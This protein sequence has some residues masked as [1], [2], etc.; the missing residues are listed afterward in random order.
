MPFFTY[1]WIRDNKWL[2]LLSGIVGLLLISPIAEVYNDQDAIITPITG[3]VLLA[4]TFGTAENR[5]TIWGMG[6]LTLC[7]MIVSIATDGSGLFAGFKDAN[8]VAPV[9]F[10]FI[11][12][13]IFFLLARWMFRAVH[14]NREVLCAAICGYLLIGILW[15]GLYAVM[16]SIYPHSLINGDGSSISLNGGNEN[17]SLGDILYFSFITLTTTGFGDIVPKHPAIRMLTV[18]EAIVGIYYN[19]I[20]IARFVSLYGM[21]VPNKGGNNDKA[22]V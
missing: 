22:S 6:G 14:V 1:R 4:V 18:V 15:T 5:R 3:I 12:S 13:S 2:L 8:L 11:L 9:L 17:V 7:W 21:A 10:M 20:V 16:V 19:T